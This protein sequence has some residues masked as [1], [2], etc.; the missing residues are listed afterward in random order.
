[1]RTTTGN[2]FYLLWLG[3][4]VA[5]MCFT[6]HVWLDTNDWT[7]VAIVTICTLWTA[8]PMSEIAGLYWS[9]FSYAR[10]YVRSIL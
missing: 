3:L 6:Y 2:I 1:M 8:W 4:M 9:T 5:N 7:K 10:D